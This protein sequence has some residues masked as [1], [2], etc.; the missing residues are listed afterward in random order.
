M[1]PFKRESRR[2]PQQVQLGAEA[3]ESR[4]LLTGGAGNT[5]AIV[6]GTIDKPGDTVSVS[7]TL[8]QSNFTR[9]KNKVAMGVDV[10]ADSAGSLKPLIASV[11]DPHGTVVPQTFHSIYDP[12]VKHRQVSNGKGTSAVLSPLTSFPSNP[13]EPVTYTVQVQAQSQTT[14]KFLLGFYLP[15]DA[16]G[17]GK[18]DKA[19]L[20]AVKAMRGAKAGDNRYSFDADVNRDGRIGPIDIS[21]T[22][23][24]QGVS[25]T[26]SPVIAANLDTASVSNPSAR[27]NNMPT[28]RF[29][30]S[31]SPNATVVY[32]NT[33]DPSMAP[34]TTTVDPTGNYTIVTPLAQGENVFQVSSS[35][36]FGQT[37]KG[38]IAPVTYRP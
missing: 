4:E 24:N 8:T 28:A 34:I 37:I 9:P 27:V 22:Q 25:T 33:S 23:Q 2:R 32:Q 10:V 13:A 21:Y 14:G 12:H 6:P 35:D 17:D 16:N 7:F 15:G 26:I 29:T 20:K 36:S 11:T 1:N 18:V 5:F 19:D 38:N 3:L 30:G 31:A